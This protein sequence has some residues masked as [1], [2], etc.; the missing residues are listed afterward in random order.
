MYYHGLNKF[1]VQLNLIKQVTVKVERG[2]VL[3][4]QL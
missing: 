4:N 1:F 3:I 2:V